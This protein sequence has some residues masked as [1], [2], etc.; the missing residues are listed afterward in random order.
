MLDDVERSDG[1]QWLTSTQSGLLSDAGHVVQYSHASTIGYTAMGQ[2]AEDSF[3]SLVSSAPAA[4]ARGSGGTDISK[5]P[6]S[7]LC[8]GYGGSHCREGLFSAG[9]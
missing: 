7:P 4:L 2:A 8:L 6:D 3:D 1:E 5:E 9:S